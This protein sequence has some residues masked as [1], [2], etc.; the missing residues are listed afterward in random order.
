LKGLNLN[1]KA[2]ICRKGKVD[3]NTKCPHCGPSFIGECRHQPKVYGAEMPLFET[4]QGE[5]IKELE[6]ENKKLMLA[7]ADISNMC[8]GDVAMGYGLCAQTIGE[9]IYHC[10]G[11]TN[12][13]LNDLDA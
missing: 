5:R 4:K 13:Q 7:M 9:T 1:N 8:I 2:A 12:P 6:A 3:M 10:T 11:L